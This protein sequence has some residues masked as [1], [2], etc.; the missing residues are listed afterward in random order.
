MADDAWRLTGDEGDDIDCNQITS[1][2]FA[3]VLD[4]LEASGDTDTLPPAIS[5]GIYFGLG[6]SDP[7][8]TAVD[9]FVLN[10]YVFDFE[11]MGVF[12]TPGA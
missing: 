8:E 6:A 11:P 10:G 2:T 12:V 1:C 4:A 9:A 7:A 3:E 5:T